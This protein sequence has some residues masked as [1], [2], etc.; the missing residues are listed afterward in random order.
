LGQNDPED[1]DEKITFGFKT[2][3]YLSFPFKEGELVILV[4]NSN[5]KKIYFP[6]MLKLVFDTREQ[7]EF[8]YKELVDRFTKLSTQQRLVN[9]DDTKKAAF[10]DENAKPL[11]S[12][13]FWR[14]KGNVLTKGY[15]IWFYLGRFEN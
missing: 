11:T 13:E 7:S 8:A 14:T 1:H 15:I 12:V 10:T 3:P 4:N 6:P 5:G 2:H 9:E